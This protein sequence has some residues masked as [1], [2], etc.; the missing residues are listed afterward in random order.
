MIDSLLGACDTFLNLVTGRGGPTSRFS[1]AGMPNGF[2]LNDLLWFGDGA[3]KKT[4]ISR[5]FMVEPGEISAFSV[6]QLNDLHE[7]LRI[8]LGI[9]GE[10]FALQVQ[11]SIDSDYRHELETYHRETLN[12]RRQDPVHGQFGVL[13]RAERYE[14]YKAAMEEGRLRRER[15]TLF[16]T[17]IIDT[18]VPVAGYPA[19]AAYFDTLSRKESLALCDFAMGALSRLF[20]DCRITPMGDRDH[21]LFYYR[22][23][24]TNLQATAIDPMELLD[25]GYSIQQNCLHG[26]G[27]TPP[28][29]TGVSFKLDC[30]YHAIF[31]VRQWPRR[32]FPGIV[33]ALTGM[34]FQ[35][36]AITMNIY[37]KRVDKVIE[38]EEQ[39]IQR[40]QIDAVSERK[41]SL[42]TDLVAKQEKVTELQQGKVIPLNALF[43]IRL[44]HRQAE[45]LAARCASL[46]NAFISMGGAVVHHATIPENARQLF[47]QTWPG[48]TIGSY[49]AFDLP[50]ED[51][52][53]ADLIPWSATFTGHLEGA[54][55]IYN[56]ARGNLVGIR[57]RL[58][59]TPQHGVLFGMTGAG[60]S[61]IIADLLAQIGHRFGFRL[62]VEEGLSH[63]VRTQTQG[64]EPVIINPNSDL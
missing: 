46:K 15:L 45:Q 18:K 43:I 62:I 47:Y 48:W 34:G 1:R 64:C 25:P 6:R 17:R 39:H 33:A 31:A 10:E 2:F 14:R 8:L 36:Y 53:L 44:W 5:G 50:A 58:G 55:A 16:F 26:E 11:W 63:A 27:I 56:G 7:R 51:S 54:E 38:K 21:F 28:A 49:R 22:F 29:E 35:E 52:Y 19:V 32:T 24:N 13:I 40:L 37:P 30:Y 41:Q 57:T 20:P 61:V 3:A 42:V 12:L 9:L 4:A 60:K 59:N 23:L